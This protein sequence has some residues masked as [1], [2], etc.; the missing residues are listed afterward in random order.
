[1]RC[2][3]MLFSVVLDSGLQGY[4]KI[5]ISVLAEGEEAPIE[6]EP[7]QVFDTWAWLRCIAI[8]PAPMPPHCIIARS[9]HAV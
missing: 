6:E 7:I 4:L 5:S 3:P 8:V 2:N 9:L 1:M